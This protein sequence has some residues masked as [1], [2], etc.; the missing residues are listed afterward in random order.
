MNSDYGT[1]FLVGK[2]AQ[3]QPTH[4]GIELLGNRDEGEVKGIEQFDQLCDVGEQAGQ[5]ID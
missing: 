4:G 5:A 3:C 2:D 1:M